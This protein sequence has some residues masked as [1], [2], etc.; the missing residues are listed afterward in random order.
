MRTDI[1]TA[2]QRAYCRFGTAP[3]P[4]SVFVPLCVAMAL[5]ASGCAFRKIPGTEIEDSPASR[6]VL[7][8]VGR[9]REGVE[10]NDVPMIVSLLDSSFYDDGGSVDPDDDL[11]IR[12]VVDTLAKRFS[13]IRDLRFS[14]TVRRIEFDEKHTRATVTYTYQIVFRMPKFASRMQTESDIKQ[15]RLKYSEKLGW[16]IVSGI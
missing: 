3:K 5:L 6:A 14:L 13:Q 8:V 10:K 2:A 16:R 12:N 7:A 4:R 11:D 15:M 9:Y 1:L